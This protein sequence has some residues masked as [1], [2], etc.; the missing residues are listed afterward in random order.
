MTADA[1]TEPL[2]R[3]LPWATLALTVYLVLRAV[4]GLLTEVQLASGSTFGDLEGLASGLSLDFVADTRALLAVWQAA[5]QTP[6]TAALIAW[7]TRA[8]TFADLLFMAA[9]AMLL[10]RLGARV[11]G[12]VPAYASRDG[13]SRLRIWAHDVRLPYLVLAAVGFD[14]LED[15]ARLV[16]VER[17]VAGWSVPTWL[18]WASWVCT[19][20]KFA[21]L[22]AFAVFLVVLLLD[23]GRLK[24][25]LRN[26]GW[27]LWRLRVAVVAVALYA[28]LLLLDP[29]GQARDL[30]RRWVGGPADLV[31]GVLTVLAAAV[32]GLAAWLL[33]RRLVLAEHAPDPARHEVTW[34]IWLFVAAAA[35]AF[36]ALAFGWIEL[37]ATAAVLAGLLLLGLLWRTRVDQE[38]RD[39]LVEAAQASRAGDAAAPETGHVLAARRTARFLAI[40]PLVTLLLL[41]AAAYA[42]ALVVLPLSGESDSFRFVVACVLTGLSLI[43]TPLVAMGGWALLRSWDGAVDQRPDPFERKYLFSIIGLAVAVAAAFTGAVRGVA[44]VGAICFIG[45]FLAALMIALGEAQRWSETHAAPPGLLVLGFTRVP[46]AALLV[47]VLLLASFWLGD[48]SEHAVHRQRDVAVARTGLSLDDAF[49]AW[50]AANCA[51]SGHS[52]QTVPLYLVAAPGGGLRAAY[53]TSSALTGLFGADRQRAVDGCPGA[54]AADRIFAMGGASG[55][56]LGV[57]AYEADLA[58]TRTATW[59]DE[60][61]GRQDYL[62]DGLTW[63]LTV[64]LARGYAGYGGQ[65]RARRLEDDLARHVTGLDADFL[66]GQWGTGRT[67]LMLLTGTQAESGCRLN[68]AG[69][70]LTDA[71]AR[72]AGGTCATLGTGAA[73]SDAPVTTDLLDFLCDPDG[74]HPQSISRATAAVLSARFPYVSPSGHLYGCDTMRGQKTAIVDGG[75]A[76]D[77]GIGMLLAL[78]PRLATLIA[79]H[80]AATGNARIVPVLIEIDNG[81]AQVAAPRAA[82]RTIEG[83]VPP[84]TKAKPDEL[85]DRA[86]EQLAGSTFTGPVP[87]LSA[88]CDVADGQGRFLVISPRTSPGLP[89]PLAWTLSSLAVDD[90]RA[91]LGTALADPG[92]SRV[93][94]GFPSCA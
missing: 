14:L 42:P 72:A 74:T 31:A 59:Y 15:V 67:P 62:T 39:R 44:Y 92:A 8:Y 5:A 73:R 6:A 48:G 41:T 83:L 68:I 36:C 22:G 53:W 32:L 47:G 16:M 28:A 3:V 55:G 25:W 71:D 43:G 69:L 13:W 70:R 34:A 45:L 89:A 20:L 56:S 1:R 52:G 11:R 46:V 78:W 87:G 90:L 84:S 7:T 58:G 76:E 49:S 66:G 57:L 33:T 80:N 65:D 82:G 94:A 12:H 30:V 85:D 18:V 17:T 64:D 21:A 88:S 77:T 75:Y 4:G 79:T 51:G 93:A 37:W 50:A 9:Y 27:A 91:Q 35:A 24:V 23:T 10:I 61:L 54:A 26:G 38:Q 29:T 60:Q 86:M 63:M 40:V 81:Y 19:T 2:P